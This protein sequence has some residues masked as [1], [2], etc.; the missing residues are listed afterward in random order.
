VGAVSGLKVFGLTLEFRTKTVSERFLSE[1]TFAVP[2]PQI[3]DLLLPILLT[4][5]ALRIAAW[6]FLSSTRYPSPVG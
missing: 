5:E 2:L 3:K 4:F 6:K 1:T